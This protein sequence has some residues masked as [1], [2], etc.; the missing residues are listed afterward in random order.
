ML[1]DKL[2]LTWC[3]GKGHTEERSLLIGNNVGSSAIKPAATI[4]IMAV[5]ILQEM[6][7]VTQGKWRKNTKSIRS[8]VV[9]SIACFVTLNDPQCH[10]LLTP[11]EMNVCKI[12]YTN[13][14]SQEKILLVL[15]GGAKVNLGVYK[16]KGVRVMS[17][18][19]CIEE[20]LDTELEARLRSCL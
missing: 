11:H 17:N 18:H 5:K 12:D 16:E 1:R 2:V 4:G 6:E 3:G 14:V 13:R 19:G 8:S 7:M 20:K 10:S 9:I 15:L